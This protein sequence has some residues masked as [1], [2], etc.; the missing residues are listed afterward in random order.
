MLTTDKMYKALVD[1]DSSFEGIFVAAIKTTGIF[2]RPTC[3][4]RKPKREN[5]EFFETSKDAI[6]NGYRPCKVCKPLEHLGSTPDYIQKLLDHTEKNPFS[7]ITNYQLVQQKIEPSKVRRWFKTH[8]GITFSGYQR[9]IRLNTAYQQLANGE[10]V[11]AAAFDNGYDSLSGFTEA[12][13]NVLGQNPENAKYV[14]VI[15]IHRFTTPLGPMIAGATEKGLCLLEF[16]DRRML[17]TEFRD[18]KKHLRANVVW[19][20][21]PLLL[22]AEQQ[23]TEYFEGIRKTFDI[24]LFAPGTNFQNLVWR[25]LME[26]SYGQSKSYKEQAINIENPNAV[27]AVAKANGCN[28]IAIIIPCHRVIGDDGS[29]TGYGGGVWRKKWLL[30]FEKKNL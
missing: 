6:L 28:R 15:N 10:T 21:H 25:K 4:A 20:Q 3:T 7:R 5:V 8:H 30:D 11:T 12:F 23:I 26:I 19:G 13:K 1:K 14:N 9:M 27:R 29:M 24:P 17:E 22:Q 16:T 18:L 2:C